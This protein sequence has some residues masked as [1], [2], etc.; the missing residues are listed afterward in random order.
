MKE[1]QSA[2]LLLLSDHGAVFCS[3]SRH[4]S[5]FGFKDSEAQ[6]HGS[7]VRLPV[8]PHEAVPEDSKR[9]VHII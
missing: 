2:N 8:V 6:W 4:G 9:K 3:C 1:M 7:R 5:L